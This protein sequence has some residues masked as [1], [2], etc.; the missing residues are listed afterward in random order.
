MAKTGWKLLQSS[1]QL[2]RL[3]TYNQTKSDSEIHFREMAASNYP[4]GQIMKPVETCY[5]FQHIEQ[6]AWCLQTAV[7]PL[8]IPLFPQITISL[9]KWFGS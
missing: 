8:Y 9:S 5:K 2:I 3:R 6:L 7:L 4:P 1:I